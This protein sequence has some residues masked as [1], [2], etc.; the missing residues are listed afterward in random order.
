[1]EPFKHS[2]K[3][4]KAIIREL[5]QGLSGPEPHLACYVPVF[6]RANA[7]KRSFIKQIRIS[8]NK[9]YSTDAERQQFAVVV[10]RFVIDNMRRVISAL[11]HGG[12]S[13]FNSQALLW[14]SLDLKRRR[15]FFEF[16]QNVFEFLSTYHGSALPQKIRDVSGL[17]NWAPEYLLQCKKFL[18]VGYC[19]SEEDILRVV[20]LRDGDFGSVCWCNA[21]TAE[22]GDHSTLG[23]N[24]SKTANYLFKFFN[25]PCSS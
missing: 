22:A 4:R 13:A 5:N 6:G 19:P 12:L 16:V 7:G 2:P 9:E 24:D 20:P 14:E 3:T 1:M 10:Q 17:D 18:N 15:S 25:Y 21:L 11:N 23:P 8:G